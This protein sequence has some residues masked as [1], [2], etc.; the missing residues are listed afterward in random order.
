MCS[1]ETL[2]VGDVLDERG[3]PLAAPTP[4][5]SY[6]RSGHDH[7]FSPAGRDLPTPNWSL[8]RSKLPTLT[9]SSNRSVNVGECP[10]RG[11]RGCAVEH[12]VTCVSPMFP[13]NEQSSCVKPRCVSDAVS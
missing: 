11:A 5:D 13:V 10:D 8:A 12:F 4:D 3:S 2:G 7:Q 1:S 9:C 6:F